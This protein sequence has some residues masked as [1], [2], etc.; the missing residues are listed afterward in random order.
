MKKK[1][2]ILAA[3]GLFAFSGCT[4]LDKIATV[5]TVTAATT[6]AAG[7]VT[8]ATTNYAASP[9]ALGAAT[10]VAALPFPFAGTAGIALGWALTAYAA[11]RN[12][13]LAT[14]LVTGIEAGRQILQT[15]PEGQKLDAKFKDVLIQHQDAAGVLNSA[16]KL[17]N[18]YT[19]DTVKSPETA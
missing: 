6:N 7:V 15:T 12:R 16:S 19:S 8:A 18:Q 14:A 17:V 4:E 1:L 5:K 13:K 11:F 9:L 10:T 2:F 3:C